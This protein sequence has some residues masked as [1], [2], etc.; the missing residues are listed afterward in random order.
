MAL[1]VEQLYEVMAQL[2]DPVFILSEDGYYIEYIGGV[3]QQ[4]YQDG[5]PLAGK[6]L[7]DVLPADMTRWVM[8]QVTLALDS[9][10]VQV[11]EYELAAVEVEGIDAS[12]GPQGMQRFEGKIAPLPSRY[13]GKRAVAWVTRNIT[14]QHELQQRLKLQS[15]TDQLTGLYNRR[16]FFEHCRQRRERE[17]PC[18]L[19]MLD[20]DHFKQINDRFG[21][22]QG[23]RALQ[24][25]C[26][27][28][29]A[30]L[31]ADDLFVR[32]GG[33]E[34]LI[35]LPGMSEPD[36]QALA[37]RIR[38]AVAALPADPVAFT[39]SLGTTL[40]QPGEEI[41]QALARADE[42]LYRAKRAGRNRVAH[43]P[44]DG[45]RKGAKQGKPTP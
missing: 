6:R 35:L 7:A 33:E 36:L 29:A 41:N 26:D 8:D 5:N 40:V 27:C 21:H 44:A 37:E 18:S 30:Q 28:V 9:G 25:F 17:A 23:D 10:Q 14:G 20:I 31:R 19:V 13:D 4:S 42:W 11:V 39:V 45:Q 16:Y 2:P 43:C 1:S 3:E 38:A 34:F 24:R 12:V 22:Q 15:E 32:S